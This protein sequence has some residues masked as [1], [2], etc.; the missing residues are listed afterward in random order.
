[1][2]GI[3]YADIT[4]TD[5]VIFPVLIKKNDAPHI[6]LLP[7]IIFN[8]KKFL[9]K[10]NGESKTA[11]KIATTLGKVTFSPN[12]KAAISVLHIGVR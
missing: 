7:E 2:K 10:V 4:E 3:S 6:I 9:N 11:K 8:Q 1:M 5:V 12:T